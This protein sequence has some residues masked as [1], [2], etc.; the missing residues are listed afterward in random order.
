MRRCLRCAIDLD[1]DHPDTICQRCEDQSPEFDRAIVALDYSGP[2]PSLLAR[3]KFQ[4][5]T[6]L[7]RPL[8]QLLA[9][10][11]QPRR[12]ATDLVLPVPLSQQRL[13]ER[14]YNQAW[15]LAKAVSQ[16]LGMEA[17]TD[18][19]ARPHHT[20][21]LMTLS[22]EERML[23]IQEAFQVMPHAHAAL[24][25]RHIAIVDDVMTTGATLN[26]C[27]RTL[28]EA[29]ARSVSAWAVAR[30]PARPDTGS[31]TADTTARVDFSHGLS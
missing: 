27:A 28:L 6:A 22:A 20:Q 4:G 13:R 16:N 17:R 8:A 12:G 18:M 15:L 9:E 26:A 7:A 14:G 23:Q 31:E 3:L 10:A 19:L 5:A 30:T 2:W 29:G 21:R 11:V 25:G 1:D 24:A